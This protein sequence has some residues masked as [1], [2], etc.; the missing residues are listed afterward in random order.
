MFS[1]DLRTKLKS[2]RRISV[3]GGWGG[4]LAYTTTV[5]FTLRAILTLTCFS[6]AGVSQERTI[7]TPSHN[8]SAINTYNAWLISGDHAIVPVCALQPSNI[9]CCVYLYL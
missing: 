4:G 5:A 7:V 8:F 1:F 2:L 3:S 6:E 9:S